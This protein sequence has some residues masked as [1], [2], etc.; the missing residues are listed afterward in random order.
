M[1]AK[2]EILIYDEIGPDDF[3]YVGVGSVM[4]QL[5]ALGKGDVT[6]RINS[7]GGAGDHGMAIY[8]ALMRH[9]GK[10]H[11][12]VD[13]VAASAASIVAMAG[14][15]IEMAAASFM[16]IHNSWTFAVGDAGHL[17]GTADLLDKFDGIQINTFAARTKQTPEQVKQWLDAETWMTADEAVARGF[18]DKIGQAFNGVAASIAHYRFRHVPAALA[19]RVGVPATKDTIAARS[20]RRKLALA[21]ARA[22][23]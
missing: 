21:R 19:A 4:E 23:A 3:G 14:T 2:R 18:A 22:N 5:N 1:A 10:I 17:R 9:D 6:V 16:M 8:N 7:P 11:V 20:A 15:T 12:I 13:A